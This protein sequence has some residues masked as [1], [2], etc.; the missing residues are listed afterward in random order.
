MALCA[1]VHIR[2][3]WTSFAAASFAFLESGLRRNSVGDLRIM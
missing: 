3:Y 2:W 1:S